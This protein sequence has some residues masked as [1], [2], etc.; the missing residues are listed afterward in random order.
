MAGAALTVTATLVGCGA[1]AD[2][3]SSVARPTT[4][5]STSTVTSS[6][7]GAGPTARSICTA[8]ALA[9][10]SAVLGRPA[11]GISTRASVANSGYP[12]CTFTLGLRRGGRLRVIAEVDVEPSAYAVLER[13]IE[14]Q[15]QIFPT[16]THPAPQ[17]VGRLGLDAS[18]F[19]EEQQLQ[20]TDAVRL[21]IATID[22]PAVVTAH[23]IALAAAVARTYL[24]RPEPKLAR[25]PAP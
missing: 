6:A 15:A 23:R 10:I 17:H 9:A 1:A 16:R 21:I 8:R 12:Q 24:G 7:T 18:W 13:T 20:T 22:W 2:H 14:E 11:A 3:A 19:P 4:S 5:R 25:G